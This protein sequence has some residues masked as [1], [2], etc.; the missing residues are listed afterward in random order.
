VGDERLRAAAGDPRAASY[1]PSIGARP[2]RERRLDR[3]LRDYPGG[4]GYTASK[5]AVRAITRTLRQELFGTPVRVT[6]VA[7]G[8]VETE[9]SRVRFEDDEEK[10]ARLYEGITPLTA[11]DVADCI[12]WALSR[13]PHVDIDEIVVRP[14]AQV[15]AT[16]VARSTPE[17]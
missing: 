14:V 17:R 8:L 11:D 15:S 5:H 10:A 16:Q 1:D 3:R 12:A 2:H 13:P 7:P 9:F 6:E 4:A